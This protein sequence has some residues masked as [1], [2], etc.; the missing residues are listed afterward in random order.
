MERG[1]HDN[2]GRASG[3][4]QSQLSLQPFPPALSV[5]GIMEFCGSQHTVHGLTQSHEI[6]G[7][8]L[9][10]VLFLEQNPFVSVKILSEDLEFPS[11]IG[12]LALH[13]I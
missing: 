7:R 9:S 12:V 8:G 10:L 3:S 6:I 1:L 5:S 2:T 11:R 13:A 4:A